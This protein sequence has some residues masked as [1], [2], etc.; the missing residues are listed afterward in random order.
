V[1]GAITAGLF[2]APTAPVTNSYE[3]IATV[4]VGS[5]GQSSAVFTSIPST[6]KHLQIRGIARTNR[7]GVDLENISMA[8]NSDGISGNTNYSVHALDG[9]GSSASA[10]AIN[11]FTRQ[12]PAL[13]TS[14]GAGA[15]M[16][17]AFVIDI[18]DYANVNKNTTVRSLNGSDIN[19][20][21]SIR[22]TSSVYLN[23][24]AISTITMAF[25]A[26]GTSFLEYSS[27]A[28]YGIKG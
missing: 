1:I 10:F 14:S 20:G 12:I 17:G 16:F 6:Y 21:G 22:L 7:G 15:N 24:A 18:L 8:F 11:S 19:G 27:I 2:S 13:I 5:G 28:L 9:D 25:S 23:T 4:N 26:A 3:S